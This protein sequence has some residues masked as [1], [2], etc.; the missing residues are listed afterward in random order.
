MGPTAARRTVLEIAVKDQPG[1]ELDDFDTLWWRRGM[2]AVHV[3][4]S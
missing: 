2:Q 1:K 4:M 3:T